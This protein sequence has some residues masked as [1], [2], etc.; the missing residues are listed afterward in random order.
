LA[1]NVHLTPRDVL[2]TRVRV[3]LEGRGIVKGFGFDLLA[4]DTILDQ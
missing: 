3:Q 2:T 4:D 1:K